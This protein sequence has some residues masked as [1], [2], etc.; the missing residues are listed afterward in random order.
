MV[1]PTILTKTEV[2]KSLEERFMGIGDDIGEYARI[3]QL[4]LYRIDKIQEECLHS[5]K[6]T[7]V[8]KFRSGTLSPTYMCTD[9]KKPI[10]GITED[11]AEMAWDTYYNQSL[12]EDAHGRS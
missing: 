11:E 3:I 9:C 2:K 6:D 1:L 10:P 12:T 8:Y 7:V 5:E 4:C